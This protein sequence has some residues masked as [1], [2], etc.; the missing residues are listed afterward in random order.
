[1]L[2]NKNSSTGK[3]IVQ[4]LG[5]TGVGKSST[6][7]RLARRIGG[8]IISAD[9]MQVYKDF[10]IGTD[11]ISRE[12]RE[13]IPHYLVDILDDCSQFN[14]SIFLRESFKIA[15]DIVARGGVPIVCGGTALYLKTMIKGIF[16]ESKKKR[17]SR[18]GLKRIAARRG[19][20]VLWN[21]LR[22]VDPEYARK[23]G[24][25][26]KVRIIRAMEIFY[27]NDAPPSE[28]F[29]QTRTPFE[30]YEFIRVGLNMQ[31]ERLYRR[32]ETRVD[33]MVARGL[34][35]EVAGLLKKYP[36]SCPPFKSVGYKEMLM[37]F[38]QEDFS[39]ADAIALIKQHSRN[40]AKRQLSWFRQEEDIQWFEPGEGEEIERYVLGRLGR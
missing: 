33:K 13:N 35:K 22:Q 32:I 20:H 29:R 27:N 39:L 28:L 17:V 24:E 19:L 18:E 10:D 5:P 9:S 12:D 26:D 6:A 7:V 14:A 38:E 30:H 34:E 40:F 23:I 15:E 2:M 3:K 36:R 1:M 8:E 37:Y 4:V 11:K 21:K 31:R 16:P 25:N